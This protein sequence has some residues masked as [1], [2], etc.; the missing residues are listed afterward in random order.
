MSPTT[1][2][3]SRPATLYGALPLNLA[4]PNPK[5]NTKPNLNSINVRVR[6]CVCACLCACHC[7]CLRG[8]M[9]M[10]MRIHVCMHARV[11]VC[12]CVCM[13]ARACTCR[14]ERAHVRA[15]ARARV[16]TCARL[17]A[18]GVHGF[19]CTRAGGTWHMHELTLC[20]LPCPSE[21]TFRTPMKPSS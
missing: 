2:L 12:A 18:R 21:K 7:P 3:L 16:C 8:W 5:R 10:C 17:C 14:Q 1:P 9:R 13:R 11:H 20:S 19:A 4:V 6:L 15:C